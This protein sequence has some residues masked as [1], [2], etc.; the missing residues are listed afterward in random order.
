MAIGER[1]QA[2]RK[3]QGW[4]QQQLAKKIG[5]SG[6]IVGRYERGEMTPSV[7]V[8]KKLA[9]TFDVTLDFLVDDTGRTAEIKD[10]AM[11]QR[12]MDIQALD[13]EDQKTI[14]HVLDSLLRDAKAKKAYAPQ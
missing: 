13:T 12:I 9:D 6:P 14:V 5:T 7:E 4:S 10:K 3:R 2:L 8:A 11:L 1:I